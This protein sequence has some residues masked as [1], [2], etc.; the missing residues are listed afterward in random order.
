MADHILRV[1][2]DPRFSRLLQHQND[3]Q[4]F[5]FPDGITGMSPDDLASYI[6]TQ[7]FALIAEVIESVDET[8][9][10]PWATRPASED[11][12]PNRDRYKGELADV[13][14]FLMNL[15]LAGGVTMSDLA[16]AVSVKQAKNRERWTSGYDGKS[17]KCPRCGR[18]YDD[19]GVR[20]QPHGDL[21]D[22]S[23][24]C[25]TVGADVDSTGRQLP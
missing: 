23:G 11:V 19:A 2:M 10:K 9:W 22:D 18:A 7:A 4:L 6:R 1:T 15:M 16:E 25:E 5:L 12:I 8:H 20:C 24:W 21:T 13:F 17:G 14:I 3:N